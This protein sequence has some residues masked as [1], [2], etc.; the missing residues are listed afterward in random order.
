[1]SRHRVIVCILWLTFLSRGLFYCVMQPMWEGYDEWAHFG[2]IQHLAEDRTLPR[3]NEP[4]SDEVRRSLQLVP[5][6]KS[7]AEVVPGTITHD[8][9]WKLPADD[10]RLRAAALRSL[11]SN[12]RGGAS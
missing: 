5:L 10:R 4:V 7:A 6:S 9:F 8:E 2:Y 1:M 12:F 3:R 11:H